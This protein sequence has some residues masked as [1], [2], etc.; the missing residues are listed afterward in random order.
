MLFRSEIRLITVAMQNADADAAAITWGDVVK[1]SGVVTK[2]FAKAVT[3][4]YTPAVNEEDPSGSLWKAIKDIPTLAK[5]PT[6]AAKLEFAQKMAI[7]YFTD[8]INTELGEIVKYNENIILNEKLL[9]KPDTEVIYNAE[10]AIETAKEQA[11]A[12]IEVATYLVKD[13]DAY[14][15]IIKA[16]EIGRAS[17]RERV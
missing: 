17:C 12:A 8:K 5:E 4:V 14:S 11:A 10:R 2:G 7:S 15:K 16:Y 3:S 6:E 9:K 1:E 13:C